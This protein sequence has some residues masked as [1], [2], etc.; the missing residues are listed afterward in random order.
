[1]GTRCLFAETGLCDLSPSSTSS[2]P[3]TI[4]P[5]TQPRP[6]SSM[7]R[8]VRIGGGYRGEG[9]SRRGEGAKREA[10]AEE[11]MVGGSG[12]EDVAPIWSSLAQLLPPP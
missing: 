11:R 10:N 5:S 8:R 6:A 12:M 4:G 2:P 1:M 3:K 9:R 7:P